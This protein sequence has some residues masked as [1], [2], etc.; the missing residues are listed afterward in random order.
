MAL[1]NRLDEM[2]SATQIKFE[3]LSTRVA[4]LESLLSGGVASSGKQPH[5]PSSVYMEQIKALTQDILKEKQDKERM[6]SELET[7]QTSVRNM[8]L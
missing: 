3:K 6:A 2:E 7:L 8:V 5:T 4:H 1:R